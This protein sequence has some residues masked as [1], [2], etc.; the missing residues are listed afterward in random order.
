[1]PL[2]PPAQR[3]LHD[4]HRFRHAPSPRSLAICA[5]SCLR[6]I[7]AVSRP[8]LLLFCRP[9]RL[10]SFVVSTSATPL[11]PPTHTHTPFP[12]LAFPF[13]LN[14]YISLPTPPECDY[15]LLEFS[16]FYLLRIVLSVKIVYCEFIYICVNAQGCYNLQ[17]V[18]C[19][20]QRRFSHANN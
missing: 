1:M 6:P 11:P 2:P 3:R 12:L 15:F 17:R 14:Y 7:Q 18:R 20:W 10:S 9:W 8:S 16:I 5:M 4:R 13:P 19:D